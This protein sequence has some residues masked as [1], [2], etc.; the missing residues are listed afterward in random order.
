[1]KI[2]IETLTPYRIFDSEKK[3]IDNVSWPQPTPMY[4]YMKNVTYMRFY[5]GK[6]DA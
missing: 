1:M 4:T 3:S 2:P 5:A 6:H